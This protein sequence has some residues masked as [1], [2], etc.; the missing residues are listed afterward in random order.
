MNVG[1]LVPQTQKKLEPKK[2]EDVAGSTKVDSYEQRLDV[3]FGKAVGQYALDLIQWG[4]KQVTQ[5]VTSRVID[6]ATSPTKAEP[7]KEGGADGLEEPDPVVTAPTKQPPEGFLG[8][9]GSILSAYGHF[10]V[11]DISSGIKMVSTDLRSA[12]S[13]LGEVLRPS[14]QSG[15]MDALVQKKPEMIAAFQLQ[16]DEGETTGEKLKASVKLHLAEELCSIAEE[17]I[18]QGED[19]SMVTL[20][21]AIHLLGNIL[22]DISGSSSMQGLSA[23]TRQLSTTLKATKTD[24]SLQDLYK[25]LDKEGTENVSATVKAWCMEHVIASDRPAEVKAPEL[26]VQP[27]L[28]GQLF[29]DEFLGTLLTSETTSIEANGIEIIAQMGFQPE[30]EAYQLVQ[31]FIEDAPQHTYFFKSLDKQ[32]D[33]IKVLKQDPRN[34]SGELSEKVKALA[35]TLISTAIASRLLPQDTKVEISGAESG[36]HIRARL[37]SKA[38]TT[39]SHTA[40]QTLS[41]LLTRVSSFKMDSAVLNI[42][43]RL[44]N[45]EESSD[46]PYLSTGKSDETPLEGWSQSFIDRTMDTFS[47]KKGKSA[48]ILGLL[49]K[50]K[51]KIG[52]FCRVIDN[53]MATLILLEKQIDMQLA[54]LHAPAPEEPEARGERPPLP[55]IDTDLGSGS[56]LGSVTPTS[57]RAESPSISQSR[58]LAEKAFTAM[59]PDFADENPLKPIVSMSVSTIVDHIFS[60]VDSFSSLK[61]EGRLQAFSQLAL[62]SEPNPD[63]PSPLDVAPEILDDP[64]LTQTSDTG[65]IYQRMTE[66][67]SSVSEKI[68]DFAFNKLILIAKSKAPGAKE[69]IL[70]HFQPNF[71]PAVAALLNSASDIEFPAVKPVIMMG[72]REAASKSL[73]Q[74]ANGNLRE[75]LFSG[76]IELETAF[77]G[78]T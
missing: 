64:R 61:S 72:L 18:A 34:S 54:I 53:P 24:I 15:M 58:E 67:K 63:K 49:S 39:A 7:M 74:V 25:Y 40:V 60:S 62:E 56:E 76:L 32:L 48:N 68:A 6:Y 36:L 1:G 17:S 41:K 27:E 3:R 59:I 21:R 31:A 47:N 11:E 44:T 2:P 73:E 57:P 52:Q 75:N 70:A 20:G 78:P 77:F 33:R 45:R 46:S 22:P 30:D 65:I 14:V 42:V 38:K 9:A 69:K 51:A 28:R 50:Q 8:T 4:A 23:L 37:M 13:Y 71:R 26:E 55:R 66:L 29:E 19:V 12:A 5:Q 43:A 16:V 35:E 10:L